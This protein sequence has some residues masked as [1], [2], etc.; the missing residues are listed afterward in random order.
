MKL[1]PLII[2]LS[3]MASIAVIVKGCYVYLD[4]RWDKYYENVLAPHLNNPA[5]SVASSEPKSG[6]QYGTSPANDE[7]GFS[8]TLIVPPKRHYECY[9]CVTPS[10]GMGEDNPADYNEDGEYIGQMT[11][12]SGDRFLCS[13]G[14]SVDKQGDI[15]VYYF[16]IS[17]I[18]RNQGIPVGDYEI[19]RD[20][21]L[22]NENN[23][24]EDEKAIYHEMFPTMKYC[25]NQFNHIFSF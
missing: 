19:D 16:E 24:S 21:N 17:K 9:G 25:I 6:T 15:S 13:M 8:Y 10:L 1:K 22:Q 2:T 11:P 12:L 20:G 4:Y 23:L 18:E 14:V 7:K 5:L 3:V